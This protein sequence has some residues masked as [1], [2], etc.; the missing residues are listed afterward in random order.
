MVMGTDMAMVMAMVMDTDMAIMRMTQKVG[1]R[2]S[3]ALFQRLDYILKYFRM[4][5]RIGKR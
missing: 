5:C 3:I 2:G 4:N 1:K